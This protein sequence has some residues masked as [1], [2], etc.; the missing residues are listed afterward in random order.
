MSNQKQSQEHERGLRSLIR[1]PF[2]GGARAPEN[3]Q[4]SQDKHAQ[5]GAQPPSQPDGS[6]VG[7]IRKASQAQAGN[8]ERGT[9]RRADDPSKNRKSTNILRPTESI[10]PV[11]Q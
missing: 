2:H 1:V 8:A 6:E 7:P 11:C 5:S 3:Q 4:G 9:H 10:P